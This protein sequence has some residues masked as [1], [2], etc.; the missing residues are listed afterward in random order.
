[1]ALE[2]KAS[3]ARMSRL[4]RAS[5][6]D[7]YSVLST[8]LSNG[9]LTRTDSVTWA[10]TKK[11]LLS[12]TATATVSLRLAVELDLSLLTSKR[13]LLA[14]FIVNFVRPSGVPDSLLA[15][16]HLIRLQR[17]NQFFIFQKLFY[18]FSK[19]LQILENVQFS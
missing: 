12:R 4:T 16:L 5:G 15:V 1:M 3:V 18:F 11:A 9:K 7:I 10:R 6:L 17:Y 8:A 14:F 13:V 19:F 2:A